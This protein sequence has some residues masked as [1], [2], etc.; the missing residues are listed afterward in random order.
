MTCST[1]QHDLRP[2][3]EERVAAAHVAGGARGDR[4]RTVELA[5]GG[6]ALAGGSSRRHRCRSPSPLLLGT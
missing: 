6:G 5:S 4:S 2:E 3:Q 1:E